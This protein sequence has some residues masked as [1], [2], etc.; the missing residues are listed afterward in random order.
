MSDIARVAIERG[1]D[2][3]PT[4][5]KIEFSPI[6]WNFAF[7]M[8]RFCMPPLKEEERLEIEARDAVRHCV[9]MI[10]CELKRAVAKHLGIKII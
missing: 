8:G 9:Y 2:Y 6:T 4:I 1:G 10:E 3:L 5:I 7:H